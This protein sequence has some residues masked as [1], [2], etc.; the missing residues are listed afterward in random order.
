SFGQSLVAE[1]LRTALT[2]A[3]GTGVMLVIGSSL[4]VNPAAKI[5]RE[6]ARAG[7]TLAII[8]N[9]PTP[10]DHDAQVLV[11]APAGAALSYLVESLN[12]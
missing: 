3:R 1:D 5:P 8:N 10:L 4:T 12:P 9:Q 6:A 11:D 2:L 7:A